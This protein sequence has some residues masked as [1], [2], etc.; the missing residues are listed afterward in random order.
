LLGFKDT[1]VYLLTEQNKPV[2]PIKENKSRG[3]QRE[4]FF[5]LGPRNEGESSIMQ[6]RHTM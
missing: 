4:A 3:L 2:L 6:L 5:P 1:C